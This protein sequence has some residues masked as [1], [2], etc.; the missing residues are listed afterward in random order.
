MIPRHVSNLFW[1]LA[2]LHAA[3]GDA[4]V[5]A[6][7][8]AA[9]RLLPDFAPQTVANTMY[10]LGRLGRIPPCGL[11]QRLASA[12]ARDAPRYAPEELSG[13]VWALGALG[14]RQGPAWHAAF[15]AAAA[16]FGGVS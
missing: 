1:A 15:D 11:L 14:V 13:A 2:T 5:A 6:L 9:T 10:A 3:P 12:V 8:A 4:T 7:C 16:S